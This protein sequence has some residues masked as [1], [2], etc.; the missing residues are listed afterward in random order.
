MLLSATMNKSTQ[1]KGEETE[2]VQRPEIIQKIEHES[3]FLNE[4][5]NSEIIRSS[6]VKETMKEM[7]ETEP[8]EMKIILDVKFLCIFVCHLITSC[9]PISLFFGRGS[10]PFL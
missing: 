4:R 5:P 6:N 2:V 7:S 10:K 9:F 1:Y 8:V 3:L